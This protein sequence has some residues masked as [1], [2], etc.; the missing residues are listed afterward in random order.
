[1]NNH[2]GAVDDPTE[3]RL[4]LLLYF[5]SKKQCPGI[6]GQFTDNLIRKNSPASI[7]NAS[8]D[9][10][11]YEG[12]RYIVINEFFE[13]F[14]TLIDFRE[15]AQEIVLSGHGISSANRLKYVIIT[16]EFHKIQYVLNIMVFLLR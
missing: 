5:T 13:S 2:S 8:L 15:I 10:Q 4:I 6:I 7:F 12:G 1:M 3:I 16:L 9:R 14:D 11:L